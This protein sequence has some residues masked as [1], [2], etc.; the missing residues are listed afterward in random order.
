M[1]HKIRWG[2]LATGGIAATFAEDLK[3][4]PDAEITAVGSRTLEAAQ[5]FAGRFDIPRAYGS[6][7][8]LAADPDV[9]VIYVATPHSA[10]HRATRICL[11]AGKAVLCEKAFTII[12]AEA[13]DLVSRARDRG[14]FLMEAMWTRFN[15]AVRR[16]VSLVSDGAIGEPRVLAADFGFVGPDD[17][18]HRLRNPELG[19]GALLD[20]GVYPVSFAHLFLGTPHSIASWARLSPQGVDE[21]T[22]I[23]LG[24]ESGALGVLSCS[25]VASQPVAAVISGSQGRIEVPRFPRPDRFTLVI[26]GRDPETFEYSLEG[27]G[28]TYQA[29]EVMRCLREGLTESPLMPWQ[30]T[31]EVMR[32]L[33]TI[34]AQIG[35]RYPSES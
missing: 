35:V 29:R 19:G 22:G 17:P 15:P 31:L 30:A 9:D 4:L 26:E 32:T 34:R 13:E 28:Y 5:A 14:L 8:E 33:D 24:Y 16:I 23:V 20:V 18:T 6:W 11:D 10:H 3:L 27:H 1:V 12:A 7:D 2:I 21:T 25:I